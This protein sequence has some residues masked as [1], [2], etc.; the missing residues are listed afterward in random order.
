MGCL[1]AAARPVQG[2]YGQNEI[3]QVLDTVRHPEFKLSNDGGKIS[4]KENNVTIEIVKHQPDVYGMTVNGT[5]HP[6]I[7]EGELVQ[8]LTQYSQQYNLAGPTVGADGKATNN[9]LEMRRFPEPSIFSSWLFWVLLIFGIICGVGTCYFG[10]LFFNRK[11][12]GE[13]DREDVSVEP[14]GV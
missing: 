7:N 5:A 4:L 9:N 6:Q 8:H 10:Y 11:K 3:K 13:V 14:V 12:G 2:V 1:L